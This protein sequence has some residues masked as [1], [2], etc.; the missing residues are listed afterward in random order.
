MHGKLEEFTNS[1][2]MLPFGAQPTDSLQSIVDSK[3]SESLGPNCS[4]A[5]TE[6]EYGQNDV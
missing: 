3:R 1:G 5:K 2:L 4:S 6:V